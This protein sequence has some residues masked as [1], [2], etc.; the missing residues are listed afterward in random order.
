MSTVVLGA[1]LSGK[2]H[3][4]AGIARN[5]SDQWG[6]GHLSWKVVTPELLR[7]TSGGSPWG[8][9]VGKETYARGRGVLSLME[10][11]L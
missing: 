3:G 2:S 4:P 10:A 6:L 11:K 7:Q 9:T 8:I 1:R 5:P